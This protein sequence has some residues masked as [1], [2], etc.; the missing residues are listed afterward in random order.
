MR[1]EDR[2]SYGPSKLFTVRHKSTCFRCKEPIEA[3]TQVFF[4]NK[5]GSNSNKMLHAQC[6]KWAK[7]KDTE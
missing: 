6:P 3:G 7:E 5:R 1:F 2:S 4:L